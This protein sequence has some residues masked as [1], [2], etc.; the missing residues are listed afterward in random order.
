MF[1]DG[2]WWLPYGNDAQFG[3]NHRFNE[4]HWTKRAIYTM[5]RL[6]AQRVL[7]IKWPEMLDV[8]WWVDRILEDSIFGTILIDDELLSWLSF[9]CEHIRQETK[10]VHGVEL[11][12]GSGEAT[13]PTYAS[14]YCTG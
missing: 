1:I 4:H 8:S 7:G 3:Y 10:H 14:M 13:S 6:H 12:G 5:A 2:K 11:T 9:L